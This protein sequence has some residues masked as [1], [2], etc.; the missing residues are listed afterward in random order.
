MIEMRAAGLATEAV[1]AL[2]NKVNKADKC[3]ALPALHLAAGNGKAEM[4][5]E[6]KRGA[7]VK[8]Y[9]HAGFP[10]ARLATACSK[11]AST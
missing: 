4:I 7:L 8:K 2:L 9:L 1:K 6:R 3:R 5:S 11:T 10:T